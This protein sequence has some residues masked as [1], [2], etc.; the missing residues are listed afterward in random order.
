MNYDYKYIE[1]RL[2]NEMVQGNMH[3]CLRDVGRI[4]GGYVASGRLTQEECDSLGNLA[5][6][7]AMNKAEARRKWE[8]DTAFGKR[9]PLAREVIT[10]NYTSRAIGWDEKINADDY[11]II[12]ENW[13]EKEEIVE[14][15]KWNPCAQLREYLTL[16]FEPEE[17]IAYCTDPFERDGKFIPSKG[18]FHKTVE[19]I[20]KS[21]KKNTLTGFSEAVGTTNPKCGAWIVINPVDG[22][23]R[24]DENITD[25]RYALVESDEKPVDEQVAIYKKLELPCACIVH[26]GGKSAHAIVRVNANSIE[27]YRKRVDFLY[28]VCGRNGLPVDKQNR[29]PSRYSRMPGVIRGDSK[30]FIVERN[31]GKASWDE[32]ENWIK[33]LNDD[34]P[35]FEPFTQAEFENPP[36]LAPELIEGVL[37]VN[38]K[39][40]VV[41]P[42]KAGKSFLL[43]ELAI[44]IAEGTYWI[45]RKCRQGRVLY[46]NLELDKASCTNRFVAVYRAFGDKPKHLDFVDRWNLRGRTMTLDK[47]TPKL[48]RRAKDMGYAAIIFDPIYKVLTGDENS[49]SD[50]A[51]F[52]NYF[53]RIAKDCGCAIV[54]CH[55]HSKGGQGDKRSMDRASGSGVFARDPD[56]MI[57]L[58][59]LDAKDAKTQYMQSFECEAIK[60]AA[61]EQD[62][63]DEWRQKVSADDMMVPNRLIADLEQMFSPEQMAEVYKAREAVKKQFESVTGWRASFTLREFASPSPQ[64]LWFRYPIHDFDDGEL[65]SDCTPE[66]E[67]EQKSWKKKKE[68]T[69][70]INKLIEF[71]N[72]IEFDPNETWTVSKVKDRFKVADRTVWNWLKQLNWTTKLGVILPEGKDIQQDEVPF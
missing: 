24:K 50:M 30:Q 9:Q 43:I 41:G 71:K 47:L 6:S 70:K 68:K 60:K 13:L 26:S 46:V 32:W 7:L 27:E 29:N 69:Q 18:T 33:D 64:N 34:L 16:L 65:L 5:V 1:E 31:C 63:T 44:A 19:E 22:K 52:C 58:L 49:A 54:Y 2:R 57:D 38:H 61:D 42:S 62:Y 15:D 55:H 53:D 51:E 23:G 4:V 21:L 39:M 56:A 12:D 28:E 11:R 35:D 36:P 17:H 10:H 48:I 72:T 59:P 3:H 45:G 40:C 37:R 66:G 20:Q 14:P 67:T 25:F 8:A